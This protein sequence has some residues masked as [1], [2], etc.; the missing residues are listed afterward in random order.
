MKRPGSN[1]SLTHLTGAEEGR[2]RYLLSWVPRS[3]AAALAPTADL[4]PVHTH[5]L[6]AA[7]RPNCCS[8]SSC[9]RDRGL[10]SSC[11]PPGPSRKRR[12]ASKD[13]TTASSIGA[14]TDTEPRCCT[15]RALKKVSASELERSS[16]STTAIL[17]GVLRLMELATSRARLFSLMLAA[18][19][20]HT[21]TVPD[22]GSSNTNESPL[23]RDCTAVATS[24]TC[25]AVLEGDLIWYSLAGPLSLAL[26]W[27][28]PEALRSPGRT[29]SLGNNLMN[30]GS[31]WP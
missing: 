16:S 20:C 3:R 9:D 31:S 22:V 1:L 19:P 29:I 11:W 10:G 14:A 2:P 12:G 7:A 18:E 27:R 26:A 13:A 17:R 6:P 23:L 30:S 25:T 28:K 24:N 8:G 15:P 5:T 4:E 21:N